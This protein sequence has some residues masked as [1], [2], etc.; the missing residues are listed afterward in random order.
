MQ[1]TVLSIKFITNQIEIFYLHELEHNI[2][3]FRVFP[4]CDDQ[5]Y[6]FYTYNHRITTIEAIEL[7]DYLKDGRIKG[8]QNYRF[9]NNVLYLFKY[10]YNPIFLNVNNILYCEE[11]SIDILSIPYY[12]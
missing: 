1:S 2:E 10:N 7:D 9:V 8:Y 11:S 4:D 12:I 3:P 5:F 6:K